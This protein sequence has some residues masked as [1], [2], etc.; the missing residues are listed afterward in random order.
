MTDQATPGYVVTSPIRQRDV[1]AEDYMTGITE[2]GEALR[3][4]RWDLRARYPEADPYAP[5][6]PGE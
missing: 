3:A 6:V 1:T 2:D 4:D 5:E